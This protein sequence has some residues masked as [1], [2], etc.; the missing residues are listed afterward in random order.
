M[1]FAA[2]LSFALVDYV[3]G[4]LITGLLLLNACIGTMTKGP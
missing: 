2:L 4:I 3:D 1:E